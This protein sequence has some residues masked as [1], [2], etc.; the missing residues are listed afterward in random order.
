MFFSIISIA[1]SIFISKMTR[2][3]I[4]SFFVK[5]VKNAKKLITKMI[6]AIRIQNIL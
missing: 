3:L 1:E 4:S 2:E 5:K 6:I